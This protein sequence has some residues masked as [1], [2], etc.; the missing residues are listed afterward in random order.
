MVET[1]CYRGRTRQSRLFVIRLEFNKFIESGQNGPM[2]YVEKLKELFC[3]VFIRLYVN[4][5]EY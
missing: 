4:R 3:T 5:N 2:L 1:C